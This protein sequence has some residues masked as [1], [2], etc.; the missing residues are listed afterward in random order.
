[1][2][3][4]LNAQVYPIQAQVNVI[5]MQPEREWYKI[6]LIQNNNLI[7]INIFKDT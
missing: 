6:K 2:Y 3:P 1:M 7:K 4:N 5:V